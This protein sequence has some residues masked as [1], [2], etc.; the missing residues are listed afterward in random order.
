MLIPPGASRPHRST[1]RHRWSS[2]GGQSQHIRPRRS[3][4][5]R[6]LSSL[7]IEIDPIVTVYASEVL[8]SGTPETKL[9]SSVFSSLSPAPAAATAA[10]SESKPREL[11]S[12]RADAAA[13]ASS[14]DQE[15]SRS[16]VRSSVCSTESLIDS[17]ST[18]PSCSALL[19]SIERK[20]A[21]ARSPGVVGGAQ[22]RRGVRS[23]RRYGRV[24]CPDAGALNRLHGG[25]PRRRYDS[26]G[27]L[28]SLHSGAPRRRYN[29]LG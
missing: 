2:K 15:D 7:A 12:S 18:L 13:T 10:S 24:P 4:V 17:R 28:N 14:R 8:L 20:V 6:R 11:S 27:A 23:Q 16:V 21:S 22:Q 3:T 25:A 29:R 1:V 9:L 26:P 5:P 19:V